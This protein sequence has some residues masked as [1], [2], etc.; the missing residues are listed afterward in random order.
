GIDDWW[1]YGTES[2]VPINLS[3]EGGEVSVCFRYCDAFNPGSTFKVSLVAEAIQ[4]SNSAID[5]EWVVWNDNQVIGSH[6]WYIGP[7]VR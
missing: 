7:F 1:Y 4:W 3:P 6:P 5:H 2:G